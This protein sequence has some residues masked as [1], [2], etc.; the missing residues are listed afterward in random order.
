MD[1]FFDIN[2]DNNDGQENQGND[3]WQQIH[4][5]LQL[6][7]GALPQQPVNGAAQP[8][9]PELVED[10]LKKLTILM[11]ELVIMLKNDN[12]V[13]ENERTRAPETKETSGQNRPTIDVN[14]AQAILAQH[15]LEKSESAFSSEIPSFDPIF[16]AF[17][18]KRRKKN[19]SEAEEKADIMYTQLFQVAPNIRKEI[20][21]ITRAGRIV[22]SKMSKCC[23]KRNKE[24]KTTSMYCKAQMKGYFILLKKIRIPTEY[25]KLANINKKIEKKEKP[26]KVKK[27]LEENV[28]I[29]KEETESESDESDLDEEYKE[30][31]LSNKPYLYW[32]LQEDK[33]DSVWCKKCLKGPEYEIV[34]LNK[35]KEKEDFNIG[36][37]MGKQEEQLRA[38]LLKYKGTFQKES[39]QLRKTSIA[40]YKIYTEDGPLVKQKIYLTSRPE[41]E[42]IKTEIQCMEKAAHPDDNKEYILYTDTS[43]LALGAILAQLDEHKKE[44]IIEYAS[45]STSVAKRNYTIT[46][47]EPFGSDISQQYA[48]H[49]MTREEILYRANTR[50]LSNP[51]KVIQQKEVQVVLEA[52]RKSAIRGHLEEKSQVKQTL[53]HNNRHQLQSFVIGDKVWQYKAKLNTRKGGKLEPKWHGPYWI[54]DV[55]YNRSYKLQT[56]DEKVVAQSVHSNLLKRV[57]DRSAALFPTETSIDKNLSAYLQDLNQ[58]ELS[59]LVLPFKKPG[60]D[61]DEKLA[62]ACQE[63]LNLNTQRKLNSQI[64]EAYYKLG[65]ILAKKDWNNAS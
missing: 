55:L 18:V 9:T 29:S 32:E 25:C 45:R 34:Y 1:P 41:Y 7:A 50:D 59:N 47:L 52:L 8:P 64:L 27:E 28:P 39:G 31:I 65:A 21:K 42:F 13:N 58:G 2:N 48:R 61:W 22:M 19:D 49:Y 51:L 6:M 35:E 62:Y 56:L 14:R 60:E 44:H 11:G 36:P 3:F 20:A 10:S 63:I 17:A 46:E 5:L 24:K 26:T 37:M 57:I 15:Y 54:H 38:I 40:Q 16:E 30:E 43:H 12:A 4:Q 53:D 33:R 23:V